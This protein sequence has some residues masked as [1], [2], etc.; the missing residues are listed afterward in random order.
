M[1]RIAD[2]PGFQYLLKLWV[3]LKESFAELEHA[4]VGIPLG[5]ASADLRCAESLVIWKPEMRDTDVSEYHVGISW[6]VF[7]RDNVADVGL[8]AVA[9]LVDVVFRQLRR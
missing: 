2:L 1:N 9:A 8:S 3:V 7:D 6:E 4:Q 5:G